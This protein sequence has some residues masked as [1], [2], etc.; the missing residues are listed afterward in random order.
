MDIDDHQSH[1]VL[2]ADD[3]PVVEEKA[4]VPHPQNSIGKGWKGLDGRQK[5]SV[6]ALGLSALLL[7]LF[8]LAG[9]T[10]NLQRSSATDPVTPPTAPPSPTPSPT[11]GVFNK[12]VLL[13]GSTAYMQASPTVVSTKLN[14][15]YE[16]W[17]KPSTD[18]FSSAYLFNEP[19]VAETGDGFGLIMWS[20]KNDDGS[21]W[22]GHQVFV[23]TTVGSECYGSFAH[24]ENLPAG[25]GDFIKSWRHVALVIDQGGL[26]NLFING[27]KAPEN[28]TISGVCSLTGVLSAGALLEGQNVLA[29]FPGQIDEFRVSSVARYS[30]DFGVLRPRPFKADASTTALYHFDDNF[31]DVSRG[32]FNGQG[33][34]T[35]QFVNNGL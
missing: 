4:S 32:K 27:K 33:F 3:T 14:T 34:G 6:L 16:M 1:I 11:P 2:P 13:D 9:I 31:L 35:Y 29:P 17:V 12:A 5:A 8:V 10:Q 18:D 24:V 15:T 30:A 21:Y 26:V 19:Q 23:P 7:P 22:V 25:S 20:G 28:K